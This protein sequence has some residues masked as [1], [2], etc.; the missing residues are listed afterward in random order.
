MRIAFSNDHAA[1]DTRQAILD[2]I[3]ALG[4][5]VV[6]YGVPEPTS[7][8]YPDMAA[9]AARDLAEGKVDRAI[10][11]CGSGI[12]MS[13]VANRIPGVRCAMVT[14]LYGAEMSRRHNDANCLALR[15]RAQSP[16][17]NREIVKAWLQTPFEGGR[18]QGRVEKIDS[19]ACRI[20]EETRKG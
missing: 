10:L 11:A 2:E 6:D 17:L 15:S 12:G 1:L 19:V 4:H 16:D 8:D 13:I 5:E 3:K 20:T 14:D 7:V 18:H 9:P